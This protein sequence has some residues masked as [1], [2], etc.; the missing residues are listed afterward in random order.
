MWVLKDF[1]KWYGKIDNFNCSD[2]A[3]ID[4]NVDSWETRFHLNGALPFSSD[5][6]VHSIASKFYENPLIADTDTLNDIS[7]VKFLLYLAKLFHDVSFNQES[8]DGI[9]ALSSQLGGLPASN[10]T[11]IENEFHSST[12]NP[13]VISKCIELLVFKKNNA[14]FG[15]YNFNPPVLNYI[16]LNSE[17]ERVE[18]KLTAANINISNPSNGQTFYVDEPINIHVLS[19]GLSQVTAFMHYDPGV[20][21]AAGKATSGDVSFI[22]ASPFHSIG[23]KKLIAI[24]FDSIANTAVYDTISINIIPHDNSILD[25]SVP[26]YTS[27]YLDDSV[28]LKL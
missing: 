4:L 9:V 2:N 8:N 6:A 16:N 28:F 23:K 13:Q 12:Q 27:V 3:F 25:I 24:G 19:Q 22:M 26:A 1:I 10:S 20:F 17:V 5:V 11:T 7:N 18:N 14:A 15:R 21:Y